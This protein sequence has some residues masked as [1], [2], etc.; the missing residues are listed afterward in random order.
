MIPCEVIY[1]SHFSSEDGFFL[2][3]ELKE[4]SR[5]F[6]LSK[7]CYDNRGRLV[8]LPRIGQKVFIYNSIIALDGYDLLRI[9]DIQIRY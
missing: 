9:K 7:V 5:I 8:E 1:S 4:K 3:K 6:H 2:L